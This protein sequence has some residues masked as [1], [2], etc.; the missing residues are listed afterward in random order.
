[1]EDEIDD[2]L[3]NIGDRFYWEGSLIGQWST[4]EQKISELSLEKQHLLDI[5]SKWE[6]EAVLN[7]A[8]HRASDALDRLSILNKKYAVL[9]LTKYLNQ[10]TNG[11]N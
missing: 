7:E 1:M 10:L 4:N 8:K 2:F 9:F 6:I 5:K 3:I 11:D